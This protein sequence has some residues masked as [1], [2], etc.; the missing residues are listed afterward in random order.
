MQMQRVEESPQPS[1]TVRSNQLPVT[2]IVPVR[3][4]ARNLPRAWV[5]SRRSAR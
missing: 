3:N 1:V 2:V 4:E 5:R